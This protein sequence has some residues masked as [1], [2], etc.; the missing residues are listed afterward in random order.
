MSVLLGSLLL[1]GV[2][3][4]VVDT[5]YDPAFHKDLRQ[6]EQARTTPQVQEPPPA[7]PLRP[8]DIV[9]YHLD[10]DIDTDSARVDATATLTLKALER[11]D[12]VELDLVGFQVEEISVDGV[13]ALF[14]RD[15]DLLEINLGTSLATGE[16]TEIEIHYSGVPTTGGGLGLFI[17]PNGEDILYTMA[18]PDGAKLWFPCNDTP[19]DKATL[20]LTVHLDQPWILTSNGLQTQ[21]STSGGKTTT[22]W[23]S[24]DPMATYLM[25]FDAA[26]YQVWFDTAGSVPLQFYARSQYAF[27]AELQ[28]ANTGAMVEAFGKRYVPYPF[29][30]YGTVEAPMV[31]SGMEHQSLTLMGSKVLEKTGWDADNLVSH[32]LAHQWFG[33]YLSPVDWR[34]I[35]LNEG[36][37]T[38]NE[39][40]WKE[41][42][43][44]GDTEAGRN[45]LIYYMSDMNEWF[46]REGDENGSPLYD[47]YV[48]FGSTVYE[49]GALTLHMLRYV[50]GSAGFFATMER[51]LQE[52]G[53]GNVTTTD[54]VT[55]AEREYGGELTWFFDAWVFSDAVYPMEVATDWQVNNGVLTLALEQTQPG[56][57]YTLPFPVKIELEDGQVWYRDLWL[58]PEQGLTWAMEVPSGVNSVEFDPE[59]WLLAQAYSEWL[60][61]DTCTFSPYDP[62]GGSAGSL[63][64]A[65]PASPI[66]GT[67][68]IDE[69]PLSCST[70]SPTSSLTNLVFLGLA[71]LRR[72]R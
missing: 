39:A 7:V 13:T 10:L 33:D 38:Y 64:G 34:D 36:F 70:S 57:Q 49:R 12:G 30:K 31:Y 16:S 11:I 9:S 28:W 43:A 32:E 24:R 17:R 59:H 51:Y 62:L 52:H 2:A 26:N 61:S 41:L 71:L 3:L 48:L 69:G 60:I 63:P 37:A 56:T 15:G 54:L 18:E 53:F 67:T 42:Q 65:A 66:Y 47:P 27:N 45:A 55:A 20:D 4:P 40:V 5:G 50:M 8:I 44:G 25:S 29:E 23:I 58:T 46:Q 22:R 21:K 35:W 1:S 19:A 72:R 6:A 68:C 14:T